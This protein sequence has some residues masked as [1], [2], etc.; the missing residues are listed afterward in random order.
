MSN[1]E[2]IEEHYG[3]KLQSVKGSDYVYLVD[4]E[5]KI[6]DGSQSMKRI[7]ERMVEEIEQKE[8][9]KCP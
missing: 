4:P 9:F 3:Y 2:T 8:N 1:V 5:G 6:I 7:S